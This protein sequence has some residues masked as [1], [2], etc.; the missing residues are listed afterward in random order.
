MYTEKSIETVLEEY[1]EAVRAKAGLYFMLGAEKDDLIQ[2]GMIGLVKAYNSYDASKGSSFRTF[3][4]LC[5]SRQMLNAVK[6]SGR[7]KHAPLN[8]ALS[9][10][11]PVGEEENSPS[12]GETLA[13]G[14]DSDP[15]G[16]L[17]FAE[18]ME[19]LADPEKSFFSPLEQK[20]FSLL[21]EG[22]K[23]REIAEILG[24]T[25]KQTDNAIQRIRSKI[26]SFLQP[27]E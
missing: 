17:L 21:L 20:V 3:A 9:L 11:R 19:L 18:L 12:L 25:P 23:Y 7:E 14:Y 16:Q 2:E 4:D 15:E 22:K 13:A 10:D 26:G 24:K 1:K 6:A 8:M 5:I 27:S